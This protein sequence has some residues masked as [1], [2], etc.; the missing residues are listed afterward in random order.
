MRLRCPLHQRDRDRQR[1]KARGP[2]AHG[3]AP[4]LGRAWFLSSEAVMDRA[5]LLLQ[6]I[7][8]KNPTHMTARAFCDGDDCA[9]TP[10]IPGCFRLMLRTRILDFSGVDSV[11]KWSQCRS[12]IL[13]LTSPLPSLQRKVLDLSSD[14]ALPSTAH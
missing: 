13:V 9:L 12:D 1:W 6:E 14:S 11:P 7:C 5:H 3:R 4:R 10:R 8:P 2:A